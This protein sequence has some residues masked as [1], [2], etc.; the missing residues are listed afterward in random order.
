MK[1]YKK[2]LSEYDETVSTVSDRMHSIRKEM[3][4]HNKKTEIY[5]QLFARYRLLYDIKQ[6]CV[7]AINRINK[8][9]SRYDDILED[10]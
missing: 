7:L 8:I 5:A 4:K 6:D 9:I 2:M 1:I 3:A 10:I